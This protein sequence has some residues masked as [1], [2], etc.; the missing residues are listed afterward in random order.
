MSDRE[1]GWVYR[2]HKTGL[3]LYDEEGTD[4]ACPKCEKPDLLHFSAVDHGEHNCPPGPVPSAY[5]D[6]RCCGLRFCLTLSRLRRSPY[7]LN[8]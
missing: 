3:E 8:V 2:N 4:P 1:Q 7:V 6:C 5:A